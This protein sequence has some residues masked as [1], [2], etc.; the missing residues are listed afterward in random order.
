MTKIRLQHINSYRD[1]H[2]KLRYYFRRAGFKKVALPGLPGSA[3]FMAAYQS[4][5][6]SGTAPSEIGASRTKPWTVAFAVAGYFASRAYDG[7]AAATKSIRRGVLEKFRQEYGEGPITQLRRP[8]IERM[9]E[10]QSSPDMAI[11]FL[12][13]IRE[14][15]KFAVRMEWRKDDPTQG[16]KR[17]KIKTD[18][19]LT[20]SEDDITKFEAVFPIGTRARLA[21]A[22]GLY[23]GQ[24]R[25]D[26]VR[27]GWQYLQ[28]DPQTPGRKLIKIRQQKTHEPLLIPVHPKLQAIL[29]AV[30]RTQLT[31][32]LTQYGKSYP[33][34]SFGDT[35]KAWCREAGLPKLSFHGLR[36]AAARR[37]AEAG[38]SAPVIASITGH[39]SLREVARYT[40]GA[41]QLRLARIGIE[42]VS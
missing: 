7:L 42:A 39:R 31:F 38:C 10:R 6:S 14:L 16:I 17:P 36:K 9:M 20:W 27:M 8:H 23:L 40:A 26:V 2:G 5:L 11:L 32:L 34:K 33:A 12:I 37:L 1:R 24:R 35:F 21:M 30:P 19:Y 22:L 13:T 3:E 28:D 25:S 4:A 18:G 41:D 15:M 29:D